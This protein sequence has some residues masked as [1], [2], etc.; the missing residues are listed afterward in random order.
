MMDEDARISM[1]KTASALVISLGSA[2]SMLPELGYSK[3]YARW[4]PIF[5]HSGRRGIG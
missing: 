1:E 4:I 2:S 3:V 5:R